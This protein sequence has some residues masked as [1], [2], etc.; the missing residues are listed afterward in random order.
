MET[1][2][3]AMNLNSLNHCQIRGECPRSASLT[4]LP[5][6]TMQ[7]LEYAVAWCNVQQSSL[8]YATVFTG[9]SGLKLIAAQMEDI[10]HLFS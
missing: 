4:Q 10:R 8:F 1:V 6:C 9:E 7:R 2:T 5:H 3:P